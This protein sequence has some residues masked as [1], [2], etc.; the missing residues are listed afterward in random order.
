MILYF[1]ATGNSEYIAKMI[2]DKLGDETYSLTQDI[3]T[4]VKTGQGAS[5]T[6]EKPYV[7]V[8][9]VYLSTSPTVLRKFIKASSFSGNGKVYF[10][11]TCKS[12]DGSV[13]NSSIDLCKEIPFFEYMGVQKVQMPQNYVLLFSASTEEEKQEYY[14]NAGPTTDSICA[15]IKAG[16][17]LPEQPC[18]G[19][20]YGGT[21]LVEVWY[22]HD[23]TSTFHF[24]ASDECISCGLCEKNCPVNA[25]EMRD[26]KPKWVKFKCIHCMT[27]ISRC[28]KKAIR[29]ARKSAAN[30]TPFHVCPPYKPAAKEAAP[31][32]ETE[33]KE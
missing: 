27:C 7:F 3:K 2:A 22:N 26:G 15:K 17:M 23:F 24:H 1:S 16:E 18:S 20:E 5:F 30:G 11:P 21:K 6:S 12:A 28:P 10:V 19:F 13:P 8:F 14:R 29:F 9:P 25:I 33:N 32:T 4:F 31:A